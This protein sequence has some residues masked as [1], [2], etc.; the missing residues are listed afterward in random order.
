MCPL[1]A[2]SQSPSFLLFLLRP[3]TV[4]MVCAV[5]QSIYLDVYECKSPLY[6]TV[7]INWLVIENFKLIFGATVVQQKSVKMTKRS[8]AHSAAWANLAK[9]WRK[10]SHLPMVKA[11]QGSNSKVAHLLIILAL[12]LFYWLIGW[13]LRLT[14]L[15]SGCLTQTGLSW[16]NVGDVKDVK[17]RAVKVIFLRLQKDS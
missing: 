3:L 6:N 11:T 15:T 1:L 10:F 5:K 8:Q 7:Y 13:K 17:F 14:L 12:A 2:Q 4:P 16:R 9:R